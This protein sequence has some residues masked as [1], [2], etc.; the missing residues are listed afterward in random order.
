MRGLVGHAKTWVALAAVVGTALAAGCGASGA[1]GA[2]SPGGAA[3]A[4]SQPTSAGASAS[5]ASS[6]PPNYP[7]TNYLAY[8]GGKAGAADPSLSPVEI[9]WVNQ[10]GGA[11]D[12]APEATKGA[13]MSV[14]YINQHLGGIHGHPLK[15]VTCFV[16]DKVSSAAQ[17]GQ[18]M[19]NDPKV[20]AVAVGAVTIGNQAMESAL[21]PTRKPVIFGV[22][23][24]ETDVSYKPG[25]LLF[26]D[27]LHLEGPLATFI[28]KDLHAKTA[29]I[30]YE[31]VPG[32]SLNATVIANGLKLEHV[33]TKE[34]GF[35]PTTTDLS[36]PLI[37]AQAQAK[38]VLVALVFGDECVN[39]NKAL[40]Q[41]N[42]T[43]PV[44]TNVTCISSS[45]IKGDGG[46]L[47]S[48]YY[49]VGSSLASDASDPSGAAFAKVAKLYGDQ[50]LVSDNWITVT[51]SQI[52]TIARLL[53]QVGP[54][55]AT[56][57]RI[58]SAMRAFKG[59][60]L[61][62]PPHLVCGKYTSAPSV[63]NDE[64]QFFHFANGKFHRTQRWIG[65]PPGLTVPSS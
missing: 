10:Q 63:C 29:S 11:N 40:Q 7:V 38:D 34:V 14:D 18:Q 46:V 6:N 27:S 8:V 47:P 15:L 31:N 65:P 19:A 9:G 41:L 59:P 54:A 4:S 20:Q 57:A 52:L 17:C 39:V 36:G 58:T 62:G 1:T 2:G 45:I 53:N 48:W 55:N 49:A 22:S 24:N 12:L 3:P 43:K 50:S 51:F 37:A 32:N 56:A 35:D 64:V 30:V 44:V 61:W 5:A 23:A 26:G 60:L 28:G 16:P 33:A 13:Q 21:K 25:F 42:I